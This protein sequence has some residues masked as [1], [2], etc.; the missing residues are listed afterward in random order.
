MSRL[1][2]YSVR[3]SVAFIGFLQWSKSNKN[4]RSKSY[5]K[6]RVSAITTVRE[7]LCEIEERQRQQLNAS[8]FADLE[9][10][11]LHRADIA[12]VNNLLNRH[13]PFLRPEERVLA[14]EI[15]TSIIEIRAAMT[16]VHDVRP[17]W[18]TNTWEQPP[19]VSIVAGAASR[20]QTAKSEL[21]NRYADIVNGVDR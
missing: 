6:Q 7:T 12:R 10:E 2:H 16:A 20:L 21:G 19:E 11:N 9:E 4:E 15:I 13:S 14:I 3:L 17:D 18:W 8:Q 1:S 5:R